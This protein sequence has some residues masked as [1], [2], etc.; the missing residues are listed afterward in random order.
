MKRILIGLMVAFLGSGTV[1]AEKNP[2]YSPI[3]KLKKLDQEMAKK[4]E[5]EQNTPKKGKEDTLLS[6]E[7]VGVIKVG[8]LF[9]LE[10]RKGG[11]IKFYKPG[12]YIDG[13][14]LKKVDFNR[15]VL[16][17]GKEKQ[18]IPIN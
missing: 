17:R 10:A 13:W 12:D 6:L 11:E 1:Y 4:K 8:K 9:L 7:I 16:V 15:V 18:V 5:E 14:L 3:D 2:F